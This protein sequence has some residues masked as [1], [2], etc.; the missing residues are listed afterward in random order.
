MYN[1][2]NPQPLFF[3]KA[4]RECIVVDHNKKMLSTAQSIAQGR[5]S[6]DKAYTS[7]LQLKRTS[8]MRILSTT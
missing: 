2:S 3:F 4:R 6:E 7:Q 8:G 1:L 5:N